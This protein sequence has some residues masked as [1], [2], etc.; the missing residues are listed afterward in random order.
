MKVINPG[1]K[2]WL[3]KFIFWQATLR[4]TSHFVGFSI[5]LTTIAFFWSYVLIGL[6]HSQVARFEKSHCNQLFLASNVLL[7][8]LKEKK[9]EIL[10]YCLTS[11][12][13]FNHA[14]FRWGRRWNWWYGPSRSFSEYIILYLN[15]RLRFGPNFFDI[16]CIRWAR[17]WMSA[18][19]I[20]YERTRWFWRTCEICQY[21]LSQKIV[22][23]LL[24]H[25]SR[26]LVTS[27]VW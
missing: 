25:G 1:R 10:K 2:I 24:G 18:K 13:R 21:R 3:E 5:L 26:L 9:R 6:T 12:L 16:F 4:K 27:F 14:G 8:T 17:M 15:F 7:V 11:V 22:K 23:E 19:H 20:S